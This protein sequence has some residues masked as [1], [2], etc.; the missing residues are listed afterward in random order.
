MNLRTG[1]LGN[2]AGGPPLS[3][4]RRPEEQ[5]SP[6]PLPRKERARR[7]RCVA[8][9]LAQFMGSDEDPDV[10][11]HRRGIPPALLRAEQEKVKEERAAEAAAEAVRGK[12]LALLPH[13]SAPPSTWPTP[14]AIAAAI[15]VP[16]DQVRS[17]WN[18]EAHLVYTPSSWAALARVRDRDRRPAHGP[19]LSPVNG[20]AVP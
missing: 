16:V 6:D 7:D 5:G 3:S 10:E 13:R 11:A 18:A 1:Q 4:E 12:V 17:I 8:A 2:E 15:G 19:S 14:E 20:G 9:A